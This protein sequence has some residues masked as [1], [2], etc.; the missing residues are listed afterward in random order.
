MPHP[1][2]PEDREGASLRAGIPLVTGRG[3]AA[4]DAAAR[5]DTDRA[6]KDG[7]P[8]ASGFAANGAQRR[9]SGV[10]C[11]TAVARAEVAV[12]GRAVGDH[13]GLPRPAP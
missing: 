9:C 4:I 5:A 8:R 13:H 1:G 2:N 6:A 3:H 10:A 11:G 12:A 7:A